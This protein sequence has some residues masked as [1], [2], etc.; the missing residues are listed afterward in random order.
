MKIQVIPPAVP[1]LRQIVA[2]FFMGF[3]LVLDHANKKLRF[4]EQLAQTDPDQEKRNDKALAEVLPDMEA[5]N[6]TMNIHLNEN[7]ECIAV[8]MYKGSRGY[9]SVTVN[10]DGAV[11]SCPDYMHRHRICKH[12]VA[13]MNVLNKH[14]TEQVGAA[15][16][17]L[18]AKL[19]TRFPTQAHAPARK[20]RQEP[21]TPK[22]EQPSA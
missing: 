7:G 22:K 14:A 18:A 6:G 9:Y 4:V 5:G 13:T 12:T 1:M 20:S 2:K 16:A 11:C 19:P 15:L 3:F 8:M 21:Q 10:K 17:A